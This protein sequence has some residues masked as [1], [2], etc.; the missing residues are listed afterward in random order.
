MVACLGDDSATVR[1]P[2]EHRLVGLLVER[3]FGDGHI[4][5][6][7]DRRVLHD[8]HGVAGLPQDLVDGLPAGAVDETAMDEDD[9]GMA[10][11][12]TL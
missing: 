12:F 8:G 10:L 4:V 6:E 9:A 2:D 5:G 3:A 1:M 11:P 7:R